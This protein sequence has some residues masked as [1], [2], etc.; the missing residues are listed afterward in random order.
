MAC[1]RGLHSE[2]RY[3]M[4]AEMPN[5]KIIFAP[6]AAGTEVFIDGVKQTH[7][8]DINIRHRVGD[9][10]KLTLTSFL[11]SEKISVDGIGLV[12]QIV[13]CPSCKK[14]ILEPDVKD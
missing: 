7:L 6:S 12:K 4:L 11:V 5:F 3:A 9:V 8:T 13:V 14:E 10:P 2:W 1:K